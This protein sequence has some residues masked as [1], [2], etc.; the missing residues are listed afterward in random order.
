MPFPMKKKRVGS[1]PYPKWNNKKKKYVYPLMKKGG[2]LAH[3]KTFTLRDGTK[4][5]ARDSKDA[6]LYREECYYWTQ[7]LQ[8]Y[9]P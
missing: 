1:E 3:Y 8:S 7:F 9:K 5:K 2:Q 6:K 4:F